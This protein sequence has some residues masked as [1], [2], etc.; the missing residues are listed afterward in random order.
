MRFQAYDHSA[1]R[2]ATYEVRTGKL[3]IYWRNGAKSSHCMVP[4]W[5]AA[6]IFS[7]ENPYSFYLRHVEPN[8]PVAT[9]SPM[10]IFSRIRTGS[11]D[12]SEIDLW[13]AEMS[14]G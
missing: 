5:V 12:Q 10:G 2:S 7:S 6:A 1:V 11:A 13:E 14:A 4:E 8:Y 3:V 9:F